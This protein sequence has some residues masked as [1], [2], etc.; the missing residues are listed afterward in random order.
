MDLAPRPVLDAPIASSTVQRQPMQRQPLAGSQPATYR[1]A[2]MTSSAS[3][4]ISDMM[5]SW[6]MPGKNSRQMR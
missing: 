4:R 3:N 6:G 2:G 5:W 1:N